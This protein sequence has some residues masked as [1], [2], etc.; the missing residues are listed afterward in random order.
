[1]AAANWSE[2]PPELLN[3]ISQHIDVELDLICFQ[4]VCPTW[5]SSSIPNHHS[6]ILPFKFPFLKQLYPL[7]LCVSKGNCVIFMNNILEPFPTMEPVGFVL[8]L[9]EDQLMRLSDSPEYSNLFWPP[10]EWIVNS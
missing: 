6:N 1:M 2:L 10:P 7:N 8:D 5:R 4:S 9:N 3:L